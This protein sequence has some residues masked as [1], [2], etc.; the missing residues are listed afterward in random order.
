[1]K[2]RRKKRNKKHKQSKKIE[3]GRFSCLI[4]SARSYLVVFG[5][6]VVV[7]GE[8]VRASEAR[9]ALKNVIKKKLRNKTRNSVRKPIR[10]RQRK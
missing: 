10:R 6:W 3:T 9:N 2:K 8:L 5:R 7:V 1:M 4:S